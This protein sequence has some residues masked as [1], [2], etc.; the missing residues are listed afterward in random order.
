M[1]LGI[2]NMNF[3]ES[4]DDV[5]LEDTQTEIVEE[6]STTENGQNYKYI[7][8]L[9]GLD[10]EDDSGESVG[11][12]EK[13]QQ[14][15]HPNNG[16]SSPNN[17]YSSIATAMKEDGIFAD[18]NEDILSSITD[19]DSFYKAL[20]A[21][22]NSRIDE[23]TRNIEQLLNAGV[24]PSEIQQYEQN[25]QFLNNINEESLATED[26]ETEK[27]RRS[28]I[29]QDY[30][31]RGYSEERATRAV[32][33][34]FVAGN[35]IEDAIDALNANKSFYQNSYDSIIENARLEEENR[36]RLIQESQENLRKSIIE[37]ESYLGNYQT[38]PELRRKIYDN[39]TKPTYKGESG[40][41]LTEIQK[42]QREHSSDFYKNVAFFFTLT[43]GFK[44]LDRLVS[45]KVRKEMKK[46]LRELEHT[47]NNNNNFDTN[48][49]PVFVGDTT[50]KGDLGTGWK[51]AW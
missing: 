34:S 13:G 22:E 7:T 9:D 41:M 31:N 44:D 1:E 2:G 30:L 50:K 18:L 24:E 32:E 8:D 3:V 49:N 33:Q 20:E 37:E 6:D 39:L 14:N 17:F 35:D 26:T 47:L 43:D 48:G 45:P 23:R 10:I 19:A 11:N 25:L 12:E 16:G 40:E 29:F 51:A 21:R 38:T 27:L 5:N 15:N 42:Y 46:G 28:L 4:L 36:Q